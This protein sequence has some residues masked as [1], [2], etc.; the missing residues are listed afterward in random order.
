LCSDEDVFVVFRIGKVGIKCQITE[1]LRSKL[2]S[3]IACTGTPK[4]ID[5]MMKRIGTMVN[6]IE[7]VPSENLFGLTDSMEIFES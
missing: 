3:P 7:I 5:M 1:I 6:E 2:S 4:R